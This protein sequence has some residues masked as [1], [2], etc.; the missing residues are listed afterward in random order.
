[1]LF[2]RSL[3]FYI[4]FLFSALIFS[5]S[6]FLL[7]A[8]PLRQRYQMLGQWPRFVIWWLEKTCLLNFSVD[9][10]ENLPNTA[11]IVLSKH[12]S[13][14]ET[15][16]FQTIFPVYVLLLK[17][18]LLRIPMFGWALASLQPIAIDRQNL[19]KSMQQIVE[20][21]QR[22][23]AQGFWLVIYPEGTRVAPG[24]KKRYGIGG[25][26]LAAE[27][28]YPVVPV[29]HNSGEFWPPRGF[30]KYPGTI[31]VIIGP[32]IESKGKSAREINGLAEEWIEETMRKISLV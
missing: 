12:Q 7:L 17:R 8:L 20:Q 4:G 27:S 31:R 30:I 9:G 10:L 22:H 21:G 2:L 19:R 29:A 16:A 14:W 1:M 11:A 28:G 15:I 26:M 13:A 6:A 25:A 23:L 5:V 24:E 3:L 18:E 32:V